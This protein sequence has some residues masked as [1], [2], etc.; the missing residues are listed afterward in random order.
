MRK[1]L[2][3][4]LFCV[5]VKDIYTQEIPIHEVSSK[6]INKSPY[7]AFDYRNYPYKGEL[8]SGETIN[9]TN[10]VSW[11]YF[12][13]EKDN[14]FLI[15]FNK[16]KDRYC[17]FPQNLVPVE[18][19]MFFEQDILTDTK[20]FIFL[21][22]RTGEE[23]NICKEMWVPVHY[24]DVL[25]SRNREILLKYEPR[26]LDYNKDAYEGFYGAS[27]W[28][29][30]KYDGI[31]NGMVVFFN[32]IIYTCGGEF[33]IKTIEK[34]EYGYKVECFVSKYLHIDY[35]DSS[36]LMPYF[37]WELCSGETIIMFLYID[38]EYMD[39]YIN[40]KIPEN[41]FGTIVR[42][43]EEFIR[44]FMNLIKTNTC[45]LTN[46][47]FPYR[48]DG[49]TDYPSPALTTDTNNKEE[50]EINGDSAIAEFTKEKS[51]NTG[52]VLKIILIAGIVILLGGGATVFIIKR[53]K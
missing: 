6:V 2:L 41:K 9:A 33:L 39:I 11:E 12:H 13:P 27:E 43:K 20:T 40:E 26:L 8:Q 45:D 4:F 23:I 5:I 47:Q 15:Y 38:G 49:S 53:R 30:V 35:L 17:T 21:I 32:S 48:A 1:L 50:T 37:N 29:D 28:Y 16:G 36:T 52:S 7:Y 14:K 51:A 3:L 24:A 44:Q 19:T 31:E 25:G 42:I 34:K 10:T 46:V 22:N 18:T